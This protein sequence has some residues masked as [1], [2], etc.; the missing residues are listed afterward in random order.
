MS[1]SSSDVPRFRSQRTIALLGYL[2]A[3]QRVLAREQLA[4]LFW[5]D[6][7]TDKGKANLRRELHNLA[8]ILPD[9]WEADRVQVAFVPTH[10]TTVDLDVLQQYTAAG[11]WQAA[12]EL[13]RSDFLE[14]IDLAENPEFETW[15]L[16][17]REHWRQQA[18]TILTQLI[19]QQ[20]RLA[21]YHEALRH[22]RRLL[23]LTPWNE[24]IHR[25]VMLMLV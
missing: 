13:L 6:E 12:A 5:P 10:Q 18:E 14:G 7:P 1:T 11:E 17:E 4:A 20:S 24:S 2:V 3:E 25:Q 23:R 15:L 21:H 16:G 8:Q 19:A 22:A 9:C